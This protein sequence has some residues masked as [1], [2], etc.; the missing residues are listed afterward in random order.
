MHVWI[1]QIVASVSLTVN[2]DKLEETA[3]TVK[4]NEKSKFFLA[5]SKLTLQQ[6]EAANIFRIQQYPKLR[7]KLSVRI[8][9]WIFKSFSEKELNVIKS[10]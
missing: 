7:L 4:I 1:S 3:W 6:K 9:N 5:F 2:K 8:F 10:R